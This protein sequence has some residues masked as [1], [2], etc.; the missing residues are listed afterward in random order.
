M[1]Y[2]GWPF[3]CLQPLV[4]KVLDNH[5]KDKSYD[6]KLVSG[7]V[8]FINEDVMVGRFRGRSS[9]PAQ[10]ICASRP[11]HLQLGLNELGKPFKYIVNCVIMQNTGAGLHASISEYLDGVNDGEQRPVTQLLLARFTSACLL[12]MASQGSAS[13]SGRRRRER[14]SSPCAPS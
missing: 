8:N 4:L 11:L 1:C 12:V 7:W 10:P 5:L 14:T 13:S 9:R 2:R 3:L 6:D